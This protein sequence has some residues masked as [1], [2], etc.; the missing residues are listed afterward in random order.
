MSRT[1]N[2][3]EGILASAQR[4]ESLGRD[5][6]A[7][8]LLERLAGFRD[9]APAI[10]EETHLR[11]ADLYAQRDEFKKARRHLTIALTLQ[12]QEAAY[13]HRM[14]CWIEADPD[15]A[16]D[17][18]RRY[19]RQAVRQDPDNAAY[20]ADYGAYLLNLGRTRTGRAALHRAFRLG[21]PDLELVGRIVL[22]FR[23]ADLWDDA[24][25]VLQ[26]ARFQAARDR[27][28]LAMWQEHEFAQ[29]AARQPK[30]DAVSNAASRPVMAS[31][32]LPFLRVETR[33]PVAP[34]DGKIVRFDAPAT[35]SHPA[36]PLP[37]R[38]PGT[39]PNRR[40]R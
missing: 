39:P 13:Y 17:R 27:R 29:L 7:L 35:T 31:M 18:A 2:L 12:P 3:V 34:V 9:L 22:T 11:L 8:V 38:R 5:Q 6:A 25:R 15:A 10:A 16:L 26:L 14:A 4:L 30:A 36:L 19:Y 23:E 1:L 20:W 28:F 37:R 33:P 24:R 40:T 32:V 21:S